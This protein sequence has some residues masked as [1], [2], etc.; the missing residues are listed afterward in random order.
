M[1]GDGPNVNAI[2]RTA[3]CASRPALDASVPVLL[4]RLD[5]NPFHHG[6][7]GAIRSLGRAGVEVHALV[8]SARTPAA[9][10]RYLH[11][12]HVAGPG[13]ASA[14]AAPDGL[15]ALLCRISE[16]IG[17]PAVLIPMDDVGAVGVPELLG[18]L[19]GRFLT[20][21]QPAGLPARVA[22]KAEL[23]ALCHGLGIPHPPTVVPCS[24]AEAGRAA[25]ELGLPAVAKWSRP[26]LLRHAPASAGAR[27]LTSTALVRTS[28]DARALYA[29]S[30]EAGSR[31]L[32]QA[33]VP[34]GRA[35][36][37]FFH[38]C[39]TDVEGCALGGAGR[40]ERS[41]PVGTGLTAVGR[42]LAN[43][44]VEAAAVRLA[45]HLGYRGVLDLDFR[46]DQ[47]TG[48]YHLLD[49]N[50]RPGAQ[51]RLFTRGDGLD[52]VRALHLYLT[53]RRVP[54]G[55][56][57]HGRLFV[58]EN[59][60]A[61]SVARSP[62]AGG[63]PRRPSGGRRREVETAWAAADD[64]QPFAAMAAAWCL[65]AV[66]RLRLPA[67]GPVRRPGRDGRSRRPD[68]PDSTEVN[69]QCTTC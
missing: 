48:A 28:G 43:P 62:R 52:V 53:G 19:P 18:S 41:W 39:F 27:P 63:G 11:R 1:H 61:L 57:A 37:W 44:Q 24:A 35:D 34:G 30:V 64:P 45:E 51:F 31:L 68:H 46:R 5:P 17:R 40:K 15:A 3:Q 33:R 58:V 8:E 60:A 2:P 14:V 25:S 56:P 36:E 67:P 21:R 54:Q 10:S 42:W 7:L 4:L 29:R 65:R 22:D 13:E 9:R 32:L 47:S 16:A 26:W 55:R 12:A 6:T 59:Y 66:R 38:G 49:F 69:Q 50:P 23:A 20:P